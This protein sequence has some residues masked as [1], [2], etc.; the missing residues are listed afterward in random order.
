MSLSR[1]FVGNLLFRIFQLG[2]S[3]AIESIYQN[4]CFFNV[5]YEVDK[6][7]KSKVFVWTDEESA[8]LLK[9]VLEN[10]VNKIQGA[11]Y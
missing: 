1:Y 2:L 4:A 9:G 5:N 3:S 8:L 6:G 10:K 11:S 7:P